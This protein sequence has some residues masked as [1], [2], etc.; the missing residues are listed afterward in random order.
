MTLYSGERAEMSGDY[1][2]AQCGEQI[3]INRGDSIPLCPNCGNGTY[4]DD[5]DELDARPSM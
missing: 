3:H 2:C 4:Q 1:M 5:M